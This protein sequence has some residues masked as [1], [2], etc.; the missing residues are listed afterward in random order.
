VQH[1]K[2]RA[3]GPYVHIDNQRLYAVLC[4]HPRDSAQNLLHR[5]RKYLTKLSYNVGA[6]TEQRAQRFVL[7]QARDNSRRVGNLLGNLTGSPRDSKVQSRIAQGLARLGDLSGGDL[8]KLPGGKESLKTYLSELGLMD[9][10]A[11]RSGVLGDPK[12]REAVI[13][14][15]EPPRLRTQASALLDQISAQL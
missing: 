2:D 15:V 14:R 4:T 1:L 8:S 6:S 10:S 13:S 11:L 3:V 9:L 12:A 5:F 7:D